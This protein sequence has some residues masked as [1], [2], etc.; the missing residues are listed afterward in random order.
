M[1]LNSTFAYKTSLSKCSYYITLSTGIGKVKQK[2]C[3][4]DLPSSAEKYDCDEQLYDL[5]LPALVKFNYTQSGRMN[6][7]WWRAQRS[8]SWR[9]AATVGGEEPIMVILDGFPPIMSQTMWTGQRGPTLWVLLK[10]DWPLWGTI[11]MAL[12]FCRLYRH[13]IISAPAMPRSC[14]STRMNLWMCWRN[15]R[16]ILNGGSVERKMDEWV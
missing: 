15:L 2:G 1:F 16:T 8:S 14:I 4:R 13:F 5:N 10:I 3:M 9:S 7:L 12:R 6:C 11:T